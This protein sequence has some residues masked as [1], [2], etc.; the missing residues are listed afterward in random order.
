MTVRSVIAEVLDQRHQK[1]LML[2]K[3]HT[4]L[5]ELEMQLESL[6]QMAEE[7]REEASEIPKNIVTLTSKIAMPLAGI[8]EEVTELNAAIV[9]L[10]K[11]FSKETINI[12]VA[13]KARQGKSMNSYYSC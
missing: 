8:R 6:S 2:E 7:V 3:V 10:T 13:G 12:G 1:V 5:A 11:R 4:G 9:S